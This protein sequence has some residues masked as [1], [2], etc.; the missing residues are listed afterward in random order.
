MTGMIK[1]G[2]Y[3]KPQSQARYYLIYLLMITSF[4]LKV[5]AFAILWRIIPYII[6]KVTLSNDLGGPKV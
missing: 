3:L 2:M 4:L 6:V 1:L 5:Q